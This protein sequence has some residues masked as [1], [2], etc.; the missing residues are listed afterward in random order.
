MLLRERLYILYEAPP[1]GTTPNLSEPRPKLLIN[2]PAE[3][4]ADCF[5]HASASI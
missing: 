1:G 4:R 5:G 3:A 2:F